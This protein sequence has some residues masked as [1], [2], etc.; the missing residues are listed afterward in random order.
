MAPTSVFSSFLC[1]GSIR[2]FRLGWIDGMESVH[3][4]YSY[5]G[6]LSEILKRIGSDRS[7]LVFLGF[8]CVHAINHDISFF[9]FDFPCGPT[10]FDLILLHTGVS[11]PC[12]IPYMVRRSK[13]DTRTP[14]V[15]VVRSR[16]RTGECPRSRESTG[17][18]FTS[19]RA[20]LIITIRIIV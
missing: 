7:K 2:A 17:G 5:V 11:Y 1:Y 12:I 14:K 19:S 4:L 3:I 15:S 10:C 16:L 9:G 20:G 13:Y 6:L 18:I 8:T